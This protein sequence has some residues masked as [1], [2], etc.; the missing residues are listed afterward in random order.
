MLRLMTKEK[1]AQKR[2]HRTANKCKQQENGLRCPP[3]ALF[4]LY[5]INAI[6]KKSDYINDY[7]ID[8]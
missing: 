8:Y 6:G 2:P 1:H 4:R 7:Q 3:T 5:L